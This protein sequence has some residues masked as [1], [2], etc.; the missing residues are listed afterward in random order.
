MDEVAGGGREQVDEKVD[1]LFDQIFPE[2]RTLV[3]KFC[4]KLYAIVFREGR[5][6]KGGKIICLFINSSCRSTP[7]SFF[8]KNKS[9]YLSYKKALVHLNH[10]YTSWNYWIAVIICKGLSTVI[11][12]VW[13]NLS[14]SPWQHSGS[15]QDHDMG[16]PV[17]ELHTEENCG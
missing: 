8:Y 12:I 1:P 5:V 14:D 7:L 17:V 15:S 3:L 13:G 11:D 16:E 10:L 4:L 6:N 2:K 9:T